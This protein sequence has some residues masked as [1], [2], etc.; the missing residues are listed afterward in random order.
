MAFRGKEWVPPDPNQIEEFILDRLSLT[1]LNPDVLRPIL[2]QAIFD[3]RAEQTSEAEDF[4]DYLVDSSRLNTDK[5]TT[6]NR[7]YYKA[8]QKVV[9]SIDD[10]ERVN[11]VVPVYNSVH[12]VKE[13]IQK[14]LDCTYWPYHLTIVDDASDKKT[15]A[16]LVAF[17]TKYPEKITLLTNR[18]NSVFSAS[19]N[20]G[21]KHNEANFAY[22]CSLNSDV[23][24]TPYWLSKMVAALK[25]DPKNKIVNPVTN[26]TAVINVGMHAG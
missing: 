2:E 4:T 9:E 15:N 17:A 5:L 11:V 8:M 13:C 25:A 26:N 12:L 7:S 19:V 22:T 3:R 21:I 24:V 6:V 23:L 1:E 14:V 16:E 20:R 18:K 10:K